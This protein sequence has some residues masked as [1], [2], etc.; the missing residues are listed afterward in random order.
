MGSAYLGGEGEGGVPGRL[1]LVL[2]LLRL[3]PLQAFGFTSEVPE[4]DAG[5]IG[6]ITYM[7]FVGIGL[8]EGQEVLRDLG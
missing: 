5:Y 6:D 1:L 2:G 7:E 8:Q 3:E 4:L